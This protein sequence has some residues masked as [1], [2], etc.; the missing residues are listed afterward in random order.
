M[1]L[2]SSAQPPCSGLRAEV[3]GRGALRRLRR[4]LLLLG[5][6]SPADALP[7]V[8]GGMVLL[9]GLRAAGLRLAQGG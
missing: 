8:Q 4:A 7:W 3:A 1:R 6:R 5:G 2:A 9:G